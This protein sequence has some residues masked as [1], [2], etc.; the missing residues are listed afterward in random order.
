MDKT[1]ELLQ[2]IPTATLYV[3]IMLIFLP[4]YIYCIGAYGFLWGLGFGWLPSAIV[5]AVV[6]WPLS[7]LLRRFI[8]WYDPTVRAMIKSH[9]RTPPQ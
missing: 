2:K 8:I 4:C 3:L 9:S 6:W 5:T 1:S 7:Y